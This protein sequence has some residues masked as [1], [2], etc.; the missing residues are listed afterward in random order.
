MKKLYLTLS[1]HA[2][3]DCIPLRFG[4]VPQVDA[5]VLAAT[6]D[7]AGTQ[8][9]KPFEIR[10][11]NKHFKG[12]LELT[13]GQLI[14]NATFV[15]SL[16]NILV[17]VF[18]GESRVTRGVGEI[19]RAMREQK[20]I[21]SEWIVE[22]LYA[23]YRDGKIRTE[24][25]LIELLIQLGIE[26]AST[27]TEPAGPP[28]PS[29]DE[30]D[31]AR[32]RIEELEKAIKAA[33][34][35][36]PG[37]KNEDIALSPICTLQRVEPGLRTNAKGKEIQCTRLYFEENVPV[38]IMDNWADPLGNV[39]QKAENLIGKKVRTTSWKPETFSPLNWFRNIYEVE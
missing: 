10:K 23:P 30:L 6:L 24:L 35:D 3:F 15:V 37:Y 34:A 7:E 17:S 21:T 32:K 18:L 39:T 19:V 36:S 5:G 9:Q 33:E 28:E 4:F 27:P 8:K 2:K 31:E 25:D 16:D 13:D 11:G 12:D 14:T 20:K 38:R 29:N 26:E 22:K 1:K